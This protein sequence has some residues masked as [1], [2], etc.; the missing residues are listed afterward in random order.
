MKL[1]I[2]LAALLSLIAVAALA[3]TPTFLNPIAPPPPLTTDQR[4]MQLE[5]QVTDLQNRVLQL[6]DTTTLKI[7]PLTESR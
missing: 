5:R 1:R 6:E 3:Q 4:V 2:F 7:R